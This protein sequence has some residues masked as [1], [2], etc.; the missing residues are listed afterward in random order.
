MFVHSSAD[1]FADNSNESGGLIY[2][3]TPDFQ[4]WFPQATEMKGA[5]SST[6]HVN[7]VTQLDLISVEQNLE[8]GVSGFDI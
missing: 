6:A 5:I 2:R 8:K 1:D 7:T 4:M 3:L